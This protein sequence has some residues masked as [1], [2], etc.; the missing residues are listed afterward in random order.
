MQTACST[1]LVAVALACQ[2]AAQRRVRHGARGRRLDQPCRRP[3]VTV[4]Q[5][6]GILS[7]DGHCRTFDADAQGTVCGSGVGIVVLKRLADALADRDTVLAVIKGSAINNDGSLKVGYTAPGLEGQAQVI[8]AAQTRRRA[9]SPTTISYVEAHGTATAL[10]DPVE[11]A[12]LTQAFRSRTQRR[13]FCA[14]GS[15]KS[16][17]G[18]LD[19]A[20]GVAGLIKT[21]LALQTRRASAVAPL[22]VAEPADR[23]RRHALLRQRRASPVGIGG[24]AAARGRQLVRHRRHQ[25]A[26]DRRRG[27]RAGAGAG[28]TTAGARSVC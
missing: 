23:V 4:Y 18:H 22:Q 15:V 10:G 24:G 28:P 1:S 8:R 2:S 19:T 6:G 9:S 20:A 7:P 27:A 26:R 25:R 5:E 21:V 14:L 16:N 17:V 12:A 13:S 3:R 11:V